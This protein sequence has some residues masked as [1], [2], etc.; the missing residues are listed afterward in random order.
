LIKEQKNLFDHLPDGLIIHSNE[1]ANE[2]EGTTELSIKY[3]N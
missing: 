1:I 3:L 2:A